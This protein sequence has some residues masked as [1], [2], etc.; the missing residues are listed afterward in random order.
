MRRSL[1]SVFAALAIA[2]CGSSTAP[3]P[4]VNGTWVGSSSGLT[5]SVTLS[6]SG[7]QVT[8][9]GQLSGGATIPVTITGGFDVPNLTIQLSSSGFEPTDYTGTLSKGTI[10]GTLNGSGFD[11]LSM[12]LTKQ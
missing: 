9:T 3:K 5:M 8:G 1:L 10:T 7:S 4:T 11:N 12:T 6:Q 2:G